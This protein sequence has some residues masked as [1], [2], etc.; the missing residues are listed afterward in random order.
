MI[1]LHFP[2]YRKGIL[3]GNC[4]GY[5]FLTSCQQ[6]ATWDS[7]EFFKTDVKDFF[8]ERTILL[9]RRVFIKRIFQGSFLTVTKLSKVDN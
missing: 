9:Y 8:K 1:T 7:F 3:L 2:F 4:S 5:M 6:C